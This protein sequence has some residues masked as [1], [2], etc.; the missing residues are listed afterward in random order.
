MKYLFTIALAMAVAGSSLSAQEPSN[1]EDRLNSMEEQQENLR[2]TN[3][4]LRSDITSLQR[5]NTSME[6]Y[7]EEQLSANQQEINRLKEDLQA[8]EERR[9]ELESQIAETNEAVDSQVG[10]LSNRQKTLQSIQYPGLAAAFLLLLIAFL[11][12]NRNLRKKYSG[13]QAEI[14]KMQDHLDNSLK[15]I[16]QR[17]QKHEKEI[18]ES[19]KATGSKLDNFITKA[20]QK[21]DHLSKE[22]GEAL[23]KHTEE[24][25]QK[26]DQKLEPIDNRLLNYEKALKEKEKKLNWLI[27]KMDINDTDNS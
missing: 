14:N 9:H 13:L 1:I 11:V 17:Q 26:L 4:R 16:Q 8:G 2:V 22:A 21:H 24:E 27:K 20:E 25:K 18:Q 12:L 7:Y 5:K 10:L 3:N 6:E 23:N 19:L 15:A